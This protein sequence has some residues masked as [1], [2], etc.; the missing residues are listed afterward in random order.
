MV[1]NSIFETKMTNLLPNDAFAVLYRTN[2]QSRAIEESLRKL[3]IPY[4]IYGGLSFYRRREIKDVLAYFRLVINNNDEEALFR[5][6]NYPHRGIGKT[7]LER[8]V[9]VA[10]EQQKSPWEI[11]ENLQFY[12]LGI[13]SGIQ[14][15]IID[16]VMMIRSFSA[17]LSRLNAF[18][19]AKLIANS[20][21]IIKDLKNA[22]TPEDENRIENIEEVLNA[23]KDFTEKE[24]SEAPIPIGEDIAGAE[25]LSP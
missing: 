20:S 1:A 7:T 9:V 24:S 19:L 6:I 13:N 2:A 18:D 25:P 22:E 3:N 23:I 21:G 17:Q 16:F 5:I 10:G 14:Q 8:L 11:L 4:R 15:K 12:N